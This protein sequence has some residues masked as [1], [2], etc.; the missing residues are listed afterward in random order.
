MKLLNESLVNKLILIDRVSRRTW[1]KQEDMEKSVDDL[2][3]ALKTYYENWMTVKT[4]NSNKVQQC[5]K[6]Q[7]DFLEKDCQPILRP[8]LKVRLLRFQK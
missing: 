6:P 8:S 4:G 2:N 1:R 5:S 3:G 7:P